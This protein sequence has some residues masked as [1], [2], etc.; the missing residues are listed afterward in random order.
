MNT[1]RAQIH[2]NAV[3]LISLVI[4]VSSLGYNTWRNETTEAQ[5]NVRHAAF[6]VLES[7]GELQ[8]VAD[9]RFYY[10]PFDSAGK[11]EGELRISGFGSVAM[12]RDLMNLM[13][14][15]APQAGQEL[16]A[17]WSSSVSYLD[18]LTEEGKHSDRATRLERKL[19]AAI[20]K[21]RN[22]VIM[23]LKGLE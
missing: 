13:P 17:I 8:E 3:A 5:R 9:Y 20:N 12:I 1:I 2:R 22:A 6:R 4:A 11:T 19:T 23:V 14:H 10:L 7:L 18:E 16:H 21:S 15:P